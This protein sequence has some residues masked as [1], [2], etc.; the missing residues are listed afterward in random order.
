VPARQWTGGVARH[1]RAE[2]PAL[3]AGDAWTPAL[4][5]QNSL[6]IRSERTVIG[7]F[8]PC[9][10]ARRRLGLSERDVLEVLRLMRGHGN[11]DVRRICRGGHSMQLAERAVAGTASRPRPTHGGFC[12]GPFNRMGIQ[13]GFQAT[14][15]G[16][17]VCKTTM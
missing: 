5:C 11:V 17:A 13:A 12:Q 9:A 2:G 1:R 15:D 6:V 7:P 3:L 10:A 16:H 8:A 4:V 14:A